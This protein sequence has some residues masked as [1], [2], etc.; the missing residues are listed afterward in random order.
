MNHTSDSNSPLDDFM[1]SLGLD[2]HQ[3]NNIEHTDNN[4]HD[5]SQLH[6]LN[7]PGRV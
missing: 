3:P 2:T 5:S 4:L 1:K 7:H 6:N